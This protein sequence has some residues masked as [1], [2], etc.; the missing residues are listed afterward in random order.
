MFLRDFWKQE[1]AHPGVEE[2]ESMVVGRGPLNRL[3]CAHKN[4]SSPY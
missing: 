1:V 3:V 4:A 2:A